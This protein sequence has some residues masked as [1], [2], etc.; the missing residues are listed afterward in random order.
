LHESF[1]QEVIL[2]KLVAHS[3]R[4][5]KRVET[6]QGVW[7]VWRCG[8]IEDTSRIRDLSVGGVFIETLR[9]CPLDAT[10]DLH[11]LVEDGE[12]R[13]SA[14]VRYVM[15][16]KGLGLQFKAVKSE[17]QGRFSNMIKRIIQSGEQPNGANGNSPQ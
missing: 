11:F 13:A 9:V 5:H 8:R 6:P 12:V 1:G 16:G 2:K 15:P 4:H 3:R 7:A 17:D 10:V 14:T